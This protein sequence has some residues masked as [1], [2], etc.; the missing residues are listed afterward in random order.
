MEHHVQLNKI[1]HNVN[2]KE[3]THNSIYIDNYNKQIQDV[4]I[5]VVKG[6]VL[7]NNLNIFQIRY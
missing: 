3:N 2:I 7:K 5:I 1:E 6:Y 4:L